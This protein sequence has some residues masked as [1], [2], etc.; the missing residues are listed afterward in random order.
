MKIV[1]VSV[2]SNFTAMEDKIRPYLKVHNATFFTA[3]K[4]YVYI[5]MCEHL[6]KALCIFNFVGVRSRKSHSPARGPTVQESRCKKSCM[7]PL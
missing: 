2:T 1:N 6:R 5:Y 3:F 7:V 4:P